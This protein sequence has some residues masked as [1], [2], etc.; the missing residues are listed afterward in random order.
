MIE[1]CS[2]Q[3]KEIDLKSIERN[4]EIQSRIS[5]DNSEKMKRVIFIF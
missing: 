5:H 2:K 3:E 4:I 1:N